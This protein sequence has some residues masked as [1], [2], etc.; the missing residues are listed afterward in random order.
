MFKSRW[1]PL[2]AW[3]ALILPTTRQCHA[4]E[5]TLRLSQYSK[6]N[7]PVEDGLPHN[8]VMTIAP[9]PGGYLL[10]GTD[11]GLARFDGLRFLP[12]DVERSLGLSKRWVL[13]MIVARDHSIWVGTFD[14][15]LY[16][17]RNGKVLTRVEHGASVFSILEMHPDISGQVRGMASS[18]PQRRAILNTFRDWNAVPT[19]LGTLYLM[20]DMDRSGLLRSPD[21]TAP[22]QTSRHG[23]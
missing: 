6:R 13:A 7:W 14:G 10:V 3:L 16:Q 9:E 2:L 15:G 21:C 20:T 19:P 23:S 18:G 8:Y 4:L 17:W 1:T 5:P 12:C 22:E 11:E